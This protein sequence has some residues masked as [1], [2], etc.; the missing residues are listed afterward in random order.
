M[1]LSV[2]SLLVF[3]LTPLINAQEPPKVVALEP[4]H[5]AADVDAKVLKTLVVTFNQ[6]M[7][8]TGWSFCGGG[9]KFPKI[10]GKPRWKNNRTCEVDVALEPEHE[11]YI[12]LNC[13]AGGNFRSAKGVKVPP[14]PWS[15]TTL[16]AKLPNQREQRSL[17]KKAF[18]A[19]QDG[20]AK[21]YSYYDLR[22]LKWNKIYKKSSK[23]ILAAKTT[24]AWTSAVGKMLEPA[25]DIHLYLRHGDKGVATGRRA[26]DPLFRKHLLERYLAE[27]RP[28]GDLALVGRTK[29]GMGYLLIRGWKQALDLDKV[30]TALGK[31]RDAKALIVDVRPNSG[32]DERLARRVAQWFVRDTKVYAKNRYRTGKGKKGFGPVLDRK[33]TGN[34]DEE[35]RFGGPVV[36]LTSRYVMSSCE[37]FVLMMK[38]A[39][40]CTVVGQPTYG[41]SGNPKPHDLPNGVTIVIPSWQAL[42]PDGSCFEG[43]GVAPDLEVPVEPDELDKR[44]PIFERALETLRARGEGG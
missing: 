41:S 26:V 20:L 31:L 13:P 24:G 35:K 7:S 4:L 17:N 28:L 29:D 37:A 21:N 16:P 2:G 5:Q 30:D 33:I 15:F 32:G 18:K 14:T 11:Y 12:L 23:K 39:D 3:L 27:Q 38:Q 42:L 19:L 9:P 25:N 44:D 22:G 36:V 1:R 10:V 43:V 34:T 8:T 6:P 40:D